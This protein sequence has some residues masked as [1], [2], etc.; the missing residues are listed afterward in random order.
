M[1]ADLLARSATKWEMAVANAMAPLPAIAS[2]ITSMR[3]VKYVS[4]RPS[5]LPYLDWEY[6]LGELA[7][8]LPNPNTRITLGVRWQRLRGTVSALAMGLG[9]LG[10]TAAL[11]EAWTGRRW[12]NSFQLRFPTLPPRDTPDLER[13]EGITR[14]SV[15]KR[16]DLRRGVHFYDIGPLE[17]NTSRLNESLLSFESGIA[18][19][20]AGTIWSFGRSFTFEHT[21]TEAEGVAIGNWIA[22]V[23]DDE[24]LWKDVNT[25]WVDANFLWA[26]S[27]VLQRRA[28][29]AGWFANKPLFARLKDAQGAV[30]GYRRCRAVRPVNAQP[31]GPYNIA[32]VA[33]APNQAGTA[34]YAEALTQFDDADGREAKE[35]ALMVGA[36]VVDS[37]KPGVL[38]LAPGELTG[39]V[40]IA[41]QVV[42][43]PLRR[44]VREQLKFMVRF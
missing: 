38:W 33:Y 29:L 15:P 36:T 4:P 24:L 2:G 6:G 1:T 37:V 40:A 20:E 39:G 34:L 31:N 22:P 7:P 5:M 26:D 44:T 21:M 10:Y 8:Y 41:P 9:W 3:R 19:T 43:I 25:L 12:W 32:G 16:S 17:A 28:I 27:P 13:I 11:E 30:I 14:L 18:V 23:V 42:T 35:V